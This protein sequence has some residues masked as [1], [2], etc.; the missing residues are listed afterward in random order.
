M[1]LENIIIEG[2]RGYNNR[3]S[4]PVSQLTAF[5]GQNDVG[6]STILEA[7]DAFFNDVVDSQ[8]LNTRNESK[9][10]TIGCIFSSLPSKINLDA[11]S[12][13]TLGGEY[14]LN[15]DGKLEIYKTWKA[16]A[17]KVD[18]DRVFVRA[19]AP[20]ADVAGE[21]LFKKRDELRAIADQLAVAANRNRNPDMRAAIYAHY[22]G[23][24]QLGLQHREVEL[25]VPKDKDDSFDEARKI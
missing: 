2:F 25:D 12:E 19:N 24:G 16:T 9:K 17:A 6:K 8:D 20:T 13:T 10:F 1:R 14:L 5:V 7:L 11:T 15:G 3:C 18:L 23:L 4:V 22:Q 21:L